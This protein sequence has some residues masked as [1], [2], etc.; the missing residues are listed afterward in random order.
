MTIIHKSFPVGPLQ[1]NCTILGNTETGKGY[2]IDPGGD[3]ELIM[4]TLEEIKIELEGIYHTHAHFDHF[5]ASADIKEKTA[6]R[7]CMHGLINLTKWA[8]KKSLVSVEVSEDCWAD[9]KK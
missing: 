7:K 8:S 3:P 2:L 9:I 6:G 4:Q 5:L 1:C